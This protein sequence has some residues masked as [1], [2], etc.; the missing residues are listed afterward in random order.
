VLGGTTLWTRRVLSSVAVATTVLAGSAVGLGHSQNAQANN[1]S[2]AQVAIDRLNQLRLAAGLGPVQEDPDASQA[3]SLHNSYLLTNKVAAHQE[4]RDRPGYSVAGDRAGRTGNVWV[5]F[6]GGQTPTPQSAPEHIVDD[7][8]T[9]PFHT[10]TLLQPNLSSVG[11]A[12][13]FRGDVGTAATMPV[14]F[15]PATPTPSAPSEA[16]LFP[17]PDSTVSMTS[18]SGNEWPNPLT[19][20]ANWSPTR[21]AGLPIVIQLPANEQFRSAEVASNGR[22]MD[23]CELRS[24]TRFALDAPT[25]ALARLMLKARNATIV[26]PGDVLVPGQ[27]YDITI[28][29]TR[30]TLRWSFSVEG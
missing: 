8:M 15:D 14:W 22:T 1:V 13:E 24:S 9:S 2:P 26:M 4:E 17:G 11:F 5:Q 12:S 30:R 18:Y 19:G 20:C 29:T 3:A 23:E 6:S 28:K 16:V 27:R 21:A 25:A 10:L 7:W